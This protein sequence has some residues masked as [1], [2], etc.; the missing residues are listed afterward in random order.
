MSGHNMVLMLCLG[1]SIGTMLCPGHNVVIMLCPGHNIR[2]IMSLYNYNV[3]TPT[4]KWEV[5]R[6]PGF[7]NLL[8]FLNF[9]SEFENFRSK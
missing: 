7:G 8:E 6:L 5:F 2:E 3:T 9:L 4:E 1:H